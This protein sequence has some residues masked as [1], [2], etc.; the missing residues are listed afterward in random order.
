MNTGLQSSKFTITGNG[1]NGGKIITLTDNYGV[2]D[3]RL[4]VN[5][6]IFEKLYVFGKL[7]EKGLNRDFPR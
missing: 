6:N 7:K 5:Y 2:N 4:R 3:V 1:L